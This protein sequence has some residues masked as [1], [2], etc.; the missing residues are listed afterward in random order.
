MNDLVAYLKIGTYSLAGNA[1]S[2]KIKGEI[3]AV[4]AAY[5]NGFAIR[6]PTVLNSDIELSLIHI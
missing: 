6:I 4:G 2:V 3:A 5:H 1:T